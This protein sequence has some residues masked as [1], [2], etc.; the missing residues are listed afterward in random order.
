MFVLSLDGLLDGR[1]GWP[2]S[3]VA[4]YGV[5][6]LAVALATLARVW[7]NS[8]VSSA[9]FITFFP[10]VLIVTLLAGTAPGLLSVALSA[11]AS[12]FVVGA[13]NLP[14]YNA[15]ALFL[16]VPV[17]IMDVAAISGLLAAYSGSRTALARVG[18]LNASLSRSEA[19]FRDVVEAAPDAMIIADRNQ[20]IVLVNAEAERLFRYGRPELLGQP[21]TRLMPNRFHAFHGARVAD[22]DGAQG[23][24]RMGDGADLFG[25][26]RDGTEFPVET[27]LSVL[28]GDGDDLICSVVRDLTFR[29]E[30]QERQTLL[31]RELN[32][33]V[34]NTLASVQSIAHHTFKSTGD[35]AAFSEALEA[36]LIALSQ[37]HDVLTRNDWAG[38]SV[39]DIVAEQLSPYDHGPQPPYTLEG[40]AV[41][42]GPNRAVTLGMALGE[43]ATNAAKF[44]ALAGTGTV[45]VAWEEHREGPE[46]WLR[47]TWRERGG[48]PVTP[49]ARRGFGTRLIERSLAGGLRGSAK[50]EFGPE[51]VTCVMDFPL[52][53]GEA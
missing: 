8:W 12:W 41:T 18:E 47:L 42:L 39:A 37:S 6:V 16:F 1:L 40:P 38:A 13:A 49:P 50:L 2:G 5:T 14:G 20:R 34:K 3:L 17:A 26:R 33:R 19:R 10:A 29:K 46:T 27:N 36:R 52:L 24:R 4:R 7:L 23:P 32:H 45:H 31:I 35:P 48:P 30:T 44:G 25:L 11:A 15:S 22:F 53:A 21:L 51:G 28:P 43:L 9:Q